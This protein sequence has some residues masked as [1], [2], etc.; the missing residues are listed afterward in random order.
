MDLGTLRYIE[1][2]LLVLCSDNGVTMK[3]LSLKWKVLLGVTLTAMAAVMIESGVA[4]NAQIKS[5][6]SELKKFTHTIEVLVGGSVSGALAFGDKGTAK[7]I[8]T[9][10]SQSGRVDKVV[11]YDDASKPFVWY[12]KSTGVK[13]KTLPLGAPSLGG[14]KM[15]VDTEASIIKMDPIKSGSEVVGSIYIEVNKS[16]VAEATSSALQSAGISVVL[17]SIL[18]AIVSYF[19]QRSITGPVQVVS[20]A[21]RDM[22]DGDGDL[23]LRL[24]DDSQDELGLL[25][26]RFNAFMEK[27]HGAIAGFASNAA[28]LDRFAG[29]LSHTARETERGVVSQQADI[30]QVVES[31]REMSS[32]VQT[33]AHNVTQAAESAESADQE[34]SSGSQVVSD[35]MA[36][37]DRLAQDINGASEVINQLRQET[38][39]IGSV[40]DV[41]R[42]IAEQT[43]LLALNAAI[44]AARAGE[45][46]RGF[47]VVADEVRTLASRTQSSTQEIQE[48]IE[49]L[50]GGAREAVERMQQGTTQAGEAVQRS[51]Q[52]SESLSA[53]TGGV[54]E[55]RDRTHQIASATEQQA[56][57][58]LEIEKNM[59]S[60]AVVAR[61]A[62][63]GSTDIS[64]NISELAQMATTMK[65]TLG[66]FKL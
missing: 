49:R 36:Q 1:L 51:E 24:P 30:Q 6:N 41:I 47:A 31:V 53:I 25:A 37:I 35:T 66:Q 17:I 18:A 11:I 62:A 58:T 45:Q 59:D 48:M 65:T 57:A 15:L 43:N 21:L 63:A 52:A 5:L 14:Q 23:T 64:S 16:E 26:R 13:G 54:S 7:E 42:G 29:E 2:S 39:A 40:L 3:S 20:D 12:Q 60:I 22:A 10:L 19:V 28:E 34:S 44:E 46:G 61:Q 56:A 4:A 9:N 38:D 55:I 32:V 8:L 50:Q 27:L 33:V